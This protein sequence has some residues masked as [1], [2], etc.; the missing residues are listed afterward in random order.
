[1]SLIF[2]IVGIIWIVA[3]LSIDKASPRNPVNKSDLLHQDRLNGKSANECEK[4]R[5]QGRYK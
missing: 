3:L 1:M 2:L 5:K 4:L